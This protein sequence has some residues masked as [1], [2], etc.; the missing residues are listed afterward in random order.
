MLSV[1]SIAVNKV[2]KDGNIHT[3]G[4]SGDNIEVEEEAECVV[5]ES[6]AYEYLSGEESQK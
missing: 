3:D 6:E 4:E 5:L 1:A 2:G